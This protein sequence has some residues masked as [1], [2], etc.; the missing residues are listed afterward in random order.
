MN[1]FLFKVAIVFIVSILG[2]SGCMKE[3]ERG[4]LI[5]EGRIEAEGMTIMT[6]LYQVA[7]YGAER[8]LVYW[9]KSKNTL[10]LQTTKE[11]GARHNMKI[12]EDGW[13]N[14]TITDSGDS[15]NKDGVLKRIPK[16]TIHIVN[17]NFAYIDAGGPAFI[18]TFDGCKSMIRVP[19]HNYYIE[20]STEANLLFK[21]EELVIY[22][23]LNAEG[24]KP[25]FTSS[26]T[27]QTIKSADQ[28]CFNVNPVYIKEPNQSFQVCTADKGMNWF[29]TRKIGDGKIM[30]RLAGSEEWVSHE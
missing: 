21:H 3:R 15:N 25:P 8:Q 27:R 13:I 16:E 23:T 10:S 28:I 7:Q 20:P 12:S 14:F 2:I 24:L 18:V 26:F 19:K 1:T 30:K 5:L 6:Q 17:S 29:A 11:W 4:E 9:C 22:H